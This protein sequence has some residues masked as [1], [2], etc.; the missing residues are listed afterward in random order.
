MPTVAQVGNDLPTGGAVRTLPAQGV[1][2][3]ASLG[4][5]MA[6]RR[7]QNGQ[8]F[9]YKGKRVETWYARWW[10]DVVVDRQVRRQRKFIR[11]GT[12]KQLPT[13]RLAQRDRKSVV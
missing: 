10:E 7:H 12:L 9:R 5:N 13:A 11:L 4:E 2:E 8:L 3:S 6:R 1:G